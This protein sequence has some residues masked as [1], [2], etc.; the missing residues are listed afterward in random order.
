MAMRPSIRQQMMDEAKQDSA[1]RVQ[2]TARSCFNT[3]RC[4][5]RPE[6]FDED[7][8]SSLPEDSVSMASTPRRDPK[9]AKR[10][11]RAARKLQE[12]QL[13]IVALNDS[14]C[15]EVTLIKQDI[16][17]RFGFERQVRPLSEFLPEGSSPAPGL[18]L[19]E[20][21]QKGL[22]RSWNETHPENECVKRDA[23]IV[24]FNGERDPKKM[25][26]MLYCAERL[27]MKVAPRSVVN[28]S[29]T[30]FTSDLAADME[31]ELHQAE[32]RQME[33]HARAEQAYKQQI[34]EQEEV[35]ASQTP[36][37]A[38]VD[39]LDIYGIAPWWKGLFGIT[40]QQSQNMSF[41]IHMDKQGNPRD[42][43]QMKHIIELSKM[44][45]LHAHL[46]Q[47]PWDSAIVP[48]RKPRRA[49]QDEKNVW[50]CC[51]SIHGS[52]GDTT[53]LARVS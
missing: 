5:P 48:T 12:V 31:A 9:S 13:P 39:F 34:K 2:D 6:D 17:D 37:E 11:T 51:R 44:E 52:P 8:V 45:D 36:I 30:R 3:A 14:L 46:E 28:E 25:M 38:V 42:V 22:L 21:P 23:L 47:R 35:A 40:A 50:F 4:E 16:L 7:T 26:A 43:M 41:G 27:H 49:E 15:F 32:R 53:S 20:T 29:V 10:L 19:M 33:Q 18:L 24:E 1:R